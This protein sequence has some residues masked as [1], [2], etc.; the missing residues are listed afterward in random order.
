MTRM[1]M[2]LLSLLVVSPAMAQTHGNIQLLSVNTE[3]GTTPRMGTFLT[4]TVYSDLGFFLWGQSDRNW[5]QMYCGPTYTPKAWIQA[6]IGVGFESYSKQARVGSFLWL[7]RGRYSVTLVDEEGESGRFTKVDAGATVGPV[8]VSYFRDNILGVG[9]KLA[10]KVPHT[11][12]SLWA[13]AQRNGEQ[14]VLQYEF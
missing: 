6:G 11:T 1:T 10:V 2:V 13:T 5:A 12:L 3:A 14:L 8:R 9:P 7:G 4:G